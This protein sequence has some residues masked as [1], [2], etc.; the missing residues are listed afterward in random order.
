MSLRHLPGPLKW[1]LAAL[2]GLGITAICLA[3]EAASSTAA[4]AVT[5]DTWSV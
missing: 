3:V 5:P 1:A 4:Y 2:A